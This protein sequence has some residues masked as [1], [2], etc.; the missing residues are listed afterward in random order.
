MGADLL[1]VAVVPLTSIVTILSYGEEA[2]AKVVLNDGTTVEITPEELS[3]Y[4]TEVGNPRNVKNV[5][6][7]IMEYPSSY[8]RNG[9]RLVDTPGVGSVY[10]HNTDVAYRHLPHCDA[11][12]F[13][14]TVEQ[15]A[16][17]A[18]L[19][20][21]NDVRLYSDKIFFL[22]NKIDILSEREVEESLAFSRSAL[23]EAFG[24]SVKMFPVSAKLALKGKLDGSEEDLEKSR[25]PEFTIILNNFLLEEKG[26]VLLL[27]AVNTVSRIL[28]QGRLERELELK[29]LATPL[30]EL[31]EKIAVFEQRRQDVLREKDAFSVLLDGEMRKL[32]KDVVDVDVTA[33]KKELVP[34]MED[35]FEAFCAEKK[36]LSLKELSDAL[37]EVVTGEVERSISSWRPMEE[38]KIAEAF[39]SIC[40]RFLKKINQIID[41]LLQFSSRLFAVPF[42][43][44]TSEAQWKMESRFYYKFEEEP[45]GLDMLAS[46]LT[47]VIPGYVSSRFKKIKAYLLR[48]ANRVIVSKRREQLHRVIEIQAGRIRADLVE[49]THASMNGFRKEMLRKIQFTADGIASAVD[50][51]LQQKSQ[52]EMEL[53][54]R[55]EELLAE[56][57]T[58]EAIKRELDEIKDSA[59]AL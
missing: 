7:V 40:D 48:V 59:M 23:E 41:D 27:S 13:L 22:L 6:E 46:S 16:G 9:V 28:Q 57:E 34:A 26:K 21:L 24:A 56:S 49:R 5:R 4:V 53:K 14:L 32:I 51:G 37:E 43:S 38:D 10:L 29:A 19:D 36:D 52:G 55:R 31:K 15:P 35:K 33:F 12:L 20:F 30:E 18:E 8:L 58:M 50:K 17:K 2:R 39:R 25:L 54:K 11:A 47:E 1:P 42:E 44:I 3:G 45:V